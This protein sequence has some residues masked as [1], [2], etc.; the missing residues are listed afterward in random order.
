[1]DAV[2]KK[3]RSRFAV[4]RD[5][6][7]GKFGFTWWPVGVAPVIREDAIDLVVAIFSHR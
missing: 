6:T 7:A 5:P 3:E 4:K 1:M 2:K